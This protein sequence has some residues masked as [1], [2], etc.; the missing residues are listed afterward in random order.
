MDSQSGLLYSTACA[1]EIE[2]VLSPPSPELSKLCLR[3]G[4]P[5]CLSA[6]SCSEFS[7]YLREYVL[8]KDLR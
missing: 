5:F 3:I 2:T 8:S 4:L 6:R 1:V 7:G